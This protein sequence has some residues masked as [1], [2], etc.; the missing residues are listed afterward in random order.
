MKDVLLIIPAYNEEASIGALLDR[1]SVPEIAELCDI[2]VVNDA[3]HDQTSRIAKQR[4]AKVI[5]HVFNLGYGSALQLGYKYAVR[6]GYQYVIQIDADGQHDT[7]N[8]RSIY[9]KLISRDENGLPPDIV[10][11]S[12]FAEGSRTFPI[13]PI[14]RISIRFFRRL[15]RLTTGQSIMDSTSGL[16][17]LS[18]RAFLFYS[19]Y[20]NFDCMYPDANMVIQM[21][22]MGYR[23]LE[24]PAVMHPRETGVSMHSGILKPLLYMMIMP[25]SIL[26]IYIRIREHRQKSVQLYS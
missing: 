12:R 20:K 7:C 17:G 8:I 21:L 26:A 10:I 13:S 15:I 19:V 1:L 11:G 4:G 25:L 5:T 14:K 18:R 6:F 3:S 22:M 2:L 24:I 16:Q 9:D 23:V